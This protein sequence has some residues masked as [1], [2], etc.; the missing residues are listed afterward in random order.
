MKDLKEAALARAK[1]REEHAKAYK[2]QE[3]QKA[4]PTYESDEL[5][6]EEDEVEEEEEPV[7]DFYCAACDKSFQSQGAWTNHEQ[8]KKH[9]SNV[10]M[11]VRLQTHRVCL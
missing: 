8:S 11:C 10:A 2:E 1:E 4:A 3:W 6:D 9:K 7:D 5:S